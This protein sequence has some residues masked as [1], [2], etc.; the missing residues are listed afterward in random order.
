MEKSF[1]FG[2]KNSKTLPLWAYKFL[3]SLRD[4]N[5]ELFYTSTNPFMRNFVRQSIKGGRCNALNQHYK[6]ELSDEVF[7]SISEN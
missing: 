3:N 1:N 6:S 7:K 4:E 2:I 5:D